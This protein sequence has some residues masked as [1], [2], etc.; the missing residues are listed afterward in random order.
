MA[1]WTFLTHHARV[2]LSIA[3]NP[4]ARIRDIAAACGVTERTVQAVVSDLESTGYLSRKREGRRTHYTV[5]L[6][7]TLRHPAE[8]DLPVKVLLDLLPRPVAPG[9][10]PADS[11]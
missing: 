4:A 10:A 7:G 5:H 1:E 9:E 6:D 8:V 3:R 11:A 2:L